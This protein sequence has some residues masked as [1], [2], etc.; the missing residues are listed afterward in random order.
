VLSAAALASSAIAACGPDLA[1]LARRRAMHAFGCLPPALQ[2]RSM[3]ELHVG[4]RGALRVYL[5]EASGCEREQVYLC[6]DE[7]VARCEPTISRLPAPALHPALA[8][9]LHLLRTVSRARCPGSE[10]RVTQESQTL[11]R[12]QACDG[13]WLYHCRAHRCDRL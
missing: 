10:L 5:Y 8:R 7:P 13:R 2:L 9:A 11:Y 12:Y 3:G 1:E 4:V 6:V